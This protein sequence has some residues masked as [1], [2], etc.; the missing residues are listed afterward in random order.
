M[1]VAGDLRV[2]VQAQLGRLRLDAE[3]D[4]A[5]GTLVVI[6]PNGAGKSSLLA[7]VLGALPVQAGR[8]SLGPKL[9]LDTALG[10]N[11]PVE[12]RCI[13]YMPQDYALF[14]HLTVAGNVELALASARPRLNRDERT[15][16]V[17]AMLDELAVQS[18]AQ[19]SPQTLSGGEKQRVAL[20]RALAAEPSA[21]L[22]DEPLAAL[23][24]HARLEVREFLASYLQRLAL[25]AVVVTHDAADA[26]SLGHRIAVLEQG[27]V[28]QTGQW[29]NLVAAPGSK[30]VEEFV[31]VGNAHGAFR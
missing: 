5:G 30:F 16:R 9:L 18:L 27:R 23:D 15:Q 31:S 25:P 21:L 10:V 6:G 7:L 26:R 11:L 1:S 24:V 20:A 8:I 19:R 12:Q 22:L 3:L 17:S 2:Q 28:T 29:S 14:P 13:G 4:T